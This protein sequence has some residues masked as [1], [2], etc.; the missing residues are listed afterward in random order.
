MKFTTQAI[1]IGN[2]PNF[3]D[4][5]SGD[6][7]VPIHLSTTFARKDLCVP[8]AGYDY[9]RSG[10]PTRLALEKNL[11]ALENA[12]YAF[13]F[14]SGMAAI[15][16]VLLLLKPGDHVIAIDN[17]YGGTHRLLTQVFDRWGIEISLVA[18]SHGKDLAKYLQSNTKLIYLE[19]P[20]NP[21]MK[22]IDLKSVVK[23][24]HQ[25]KL[26]TAIDNTFVTPY[27][28]NPLDLG[29]DIV[30]H[31]AT[32]YLGGHSDVIAGCVMVNDDTL[33]KRIGFLQNAVGAIL[34]PLDSY[35]VLKGIKTLGLRLEKQEQNTKRIVSFLVN[36]KKVK[37]IYYPGLPTHP[38]H[39]IAKKQTRGFGA[40]LSIEL[41]GTL[42]TAIKFL[43]SL[44]IFSLAISCGAVESLA[45]HPATMTHAAV[46][47]ADREACG[48][49]DTLIRLSVGIEDA[50]DLIAD[51]AQALEY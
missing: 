12:K 43:Q 14:S 8:T 19:S 20:S 11:A 21:L 34:S 27:W 38:G 46:P 42:K 16:N 49:T 5:G 39:K 30:I 36:H 45:E 15:T 41:H 18:F 10:N 40:I 6:V 4:G 9:S 28:Q 24:S 47:K 31:S 22:I 3:K 2:E 37:K 1:H 23:F 50:D 44:K 48:L 26:L 25:H 33:G 17:L 51:L 32:K 7:V 35:S 13:A 29:I